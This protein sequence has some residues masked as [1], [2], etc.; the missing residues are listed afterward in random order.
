VAIRRSWVDGWTVAPSVY[1]VA[2]R[3]ATDVAAVV[4]FACTTISAW[5]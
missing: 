5:S 3:E 1:A 4:N 2:A